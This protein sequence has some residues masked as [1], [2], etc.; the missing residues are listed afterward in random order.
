MT[1]IQPGWYQDPE[2]AARRRWWDGAK[3]TDQAVAASSPEPTRVSINTNT[4]YI[5]IFALTPALGIVSVLVMNLRH[6]VVTAVQLDGTAASAVFSPGYFV[7]V[8]LSVLIWIGAVLLALFDYRTLARRGM[9]HPFHWAWTFLSAWIY[10]IGRAV[11]VGRRTGVRNIGPLVLF[12]IIEVIA[13]FV[14]L[15]VLVDAV[16]YASTVVNFG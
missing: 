4:P 6:Y 2:N 16:R 9:P 15:A 10:I 8:G 14:V 12:I 11:I 13:F 7:S 1:N 3:W 5:W